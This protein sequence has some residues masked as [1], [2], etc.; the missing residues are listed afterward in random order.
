MHPI[1][2]FTVI[3]WIINDPGSFMSIIFKFLLF[4]KERQSFLYPRVLLR[5]GG[6]MGP[7]TP[8]CSLWDPEILEPRGCSLPLAPSRRGTVLG[9]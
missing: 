9:P 7:Q 3:S 4:A 1:L 8:G 6:R 2:V 5:L